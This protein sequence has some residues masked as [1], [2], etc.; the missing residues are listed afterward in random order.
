[1]STALLY[2]PDNRPVAASLP[3]PAAQARRRSLTRPVETD[4]LGTFSRILAAMPDPDAIMLQEGPDIYDKMRSDDAV[5]AAEFQLMT[6]ILGRPWQVTPPE[7]LQG[8]PFATEVAQYATSV[9]SMLGMDNMLEHLYR[10]LRHKHSG[11]QLVYRRE[12]MTL[13]PDRF[14]PERRSIFRIGERGECFV[15]IEG[16]LR[17]A[18]PY[19]W[20]VHVNE[21]EPERPG[22]RSIFSRV[23]WPWKFKREGWS[24]WLTAMARFSVPSL[25]A[26]FEL[27]NAD[28]TKAAEFAALLNAELQ[29]VAAGSVGSLAN[30]KDVK[31]IGG[32]KD[33]QGFDGFIE[34]CERS[35]F[36]GILT[37]TLTV[38][39][40]RQGAERG[41]TSEH[42]DTADRVAEWYGLQM[43]ETVTMTA[44]AYAVLLKYGERARAVLPRF[45]LNFEGKTP[46]KDVLD[47]MD[48]G[49]PVSLGS[50][51]SD[52]GVPEPSGEDDV[53]IARARQA[54]GRT[55]EGAT[56]TLSFPAKDREEV[57]SRLYTYF[58]NK[59]IRQA[60]RQHRKD[61]ATWDEALDRL[62][63]DERWQ[64]ARKTLKNI[65]SS[66]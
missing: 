20:V 12:A 50:L 3:P 56:A 34:L 31:Q 60:F 7:H 37:T 14:I 62:E 11:G 38:Q 8:D 52:F 59:E 17:E 15:S 66:C 19:R 18:E 41:D 22:G 33:I 63:E 44:V 2:G 39:E 27:I 4:L 42:D 13:V 54:V 21:P 58:R 36:R 65:V 23:Y 47:F 28:A 51:Y 40:G 48:R 46:K 26:L 6:R 10:A 16:V 49:V 57:E 5:F 32:T 1:M 64:L 55:D 53:F 61:G 43:S 9:L 35:I 45:W 25:V 30:A 24:L 29:N